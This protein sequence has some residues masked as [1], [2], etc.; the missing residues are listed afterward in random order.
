MSVST[1]IKQRVTKLREEINHHNYL[2]YVQDAPEIPDSE[3]DRLLREL[4][5]LEQQHPE[6]IVPESP[7]QRVGATPLSE[8]AEVRHRVPMLSLNNA[9]EAQ[10]VEDFDRRARDRLAVK[11]IVYTAEPKLDGLAISL[12]YED[13][14][15]VRGA[16]RGDGATGEDVTQNVRTIDSIPLKLVGRNFPRVLEV[17]GEVIMTKSGFE[18]LNQT[19]R[20]KDEKTFA[21]PRNAAAGS[22]RQLDSRITAARPLSFYAYAVGVAEDGE[23]AKT[24]FQLLA[25]LRQWGLRTNPEIK[26]VKGVRGCLDYYHAIA[27]K[28]NRL[29]YDIDGVVYKVDE[30]A[31]QAQLGFVSRAP[32]WAVAHK[33]AAQEEMTKLVAIEVQVGRT[34]ALTPVARLEP[35]FVGGVTVTNATLHNQD[36]IER[37]DIRIGDTVI[38]R[39]AGDVIPEV[40][41]AVVSRRPKGTKKF[42]MPDKCPVCGSEVIRL[43]N[44][45]VAR[46]TGGLFC[47]AQRKQA[48]KHFAARRAMDIEGLGDKLVEQLVDQDMIHDVA[49]LYKLSVA[50]LAE[51]E[52]MGE[53]SAQNIV[54]ALEKSKATTLPR[55]L[56]ALGIRQVG[57]TT[58]RTLAQHFGNLDAIMHASEAGLEAVQDVGPVVAESI[59]HFF[60][61]PHNRKVIQKLRHAGVHWPDIEVSPAQELPLAGKTFVITGTLESMS[62]DEAKEKLEQLGGK[63]SGSVSKKTDYVIVGES[64]GSKAAKAEALGVAMLDEQ[65]FLKLLGHS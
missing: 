4:Q 29:D 41:S 37:K 30:L 13:G 17:R 11:E 61:E 9:F 2:Y 39:R 3:Y 65:A 64:P 60:H 31:Q 56:F 47:A 27:E 48:I 7:T 46:C 26:R 62:R 25:Q 45:A 1:A 22:L 63:V 6:L 12:L 59:A 19:Q 21:N 54:D 42:V 53:K 57:E 10:E 49:D 18:K 8:F 34:G 50:E 36:E 16:T 23:L 35:V 28:R 38:V 20:D 55:F 14:V 40:V 43:E 51:M 44:E 32:R 15:L 52:R 58:A 5:Q 33:F 24:Q